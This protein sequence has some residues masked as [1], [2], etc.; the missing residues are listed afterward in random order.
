MEVYRI[1]AEHYANALTC[2]GAE[3]RW[4]RAG[5]NVLYTSGSRALASL[6]LVVNRMAIPT[7]THY[8][9]MVISLADDSSLYEEL[10]KE[11]LPLNWRGLFAYPQLQQMGSEWYRSKRSLI[12][13]VPSA[14]IPQEYNFIIN[15]SHPEFSKK[16]SLVRTEDY[17]W[18]Q[19]LA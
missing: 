12:L 15:T 11:M 16:G 9:V 8:K 2:S 13:K 14:V 7:G 18:D 3:A 1:S 19:R 6:E 10:K 17:F 5:E 4:N